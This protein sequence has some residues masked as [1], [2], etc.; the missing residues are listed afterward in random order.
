MPWDRGLVYEQV[1]EKLLKELRT[2]KNERH[3]CYLSILLIQL[4]NGSRISEAVRAY[5]LFLQTKQKELRVQVSKKKKAEKR[6]M[7]IPEEVFCYYEALKI[8]DKKL[9]RS[10]YP[11]LDH[12]TIIVMHIYSLV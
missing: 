6:L 5:K 2:A 3:K 10:S 7:V 8:D 1:Y 9:R 4:R 11:T 12:S